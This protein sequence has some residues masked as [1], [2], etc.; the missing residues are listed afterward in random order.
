MDI[1]YNALVKLGRILMSA[2]FL[3]AAGAVAVFFLGVEESTVKPYIEALGTL[4]MGLA[5]LISYLIKA[6]SP[7]APPEVSEI[8][9]KVSKAVKDYLES[10]VGLKME[11]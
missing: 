4:V 8:D 7:V 10:V 11:K 3:A 9:V 2:R 6:P 5:L 1:I